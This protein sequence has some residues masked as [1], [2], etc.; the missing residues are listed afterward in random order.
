MARRLFTSEYVVGF[1]DE[2]DGPPECVF[3]GSDEEFGF[4]DEIEDDMRYFNF[5]VEDKFHICFCKQI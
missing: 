3:P 5:T 4:T 1:I 2:N